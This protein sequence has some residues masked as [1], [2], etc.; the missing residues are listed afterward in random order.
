[1]NTIKKQ[2]SR[3]FITGFLGLVF[4]TV[5]FLIKG[6]QNIL[7]SIGCG[8]LAVSIAKLFK[9]FKISKDPELLKAYEIKQ[10]E[11]RTVYI[12][13]TAMDGTG[14]QVTVFT[15][16][17][18][19]SR[20][21][22][23]KVRARG[24]NVATV[25]RLFINNGSDSSIADNNTL[26]HEVTIPATTINYSAALADNDILIPKNSGEVA[27]PIPYLPAGY[28]INVSISTTVTAGLQ[29]TVHGADY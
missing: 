9:F 15:A 17:Q 12:A 3:F 20:I 28:K 24:T 18:N 16:G 21:D 23:I 13:N 22:Q 19:G 5:G 14:T 2:I 1:M 7:I 25:L 29:V 8:L 27:V 4:L 26:V 10:S 11:E 6:D